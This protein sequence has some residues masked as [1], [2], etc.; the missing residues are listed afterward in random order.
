M[1]IL[2]TL[3]TLIT[4]QLVFGLENQ[5][6]NLFHK[7]YQVESQRFTKN[8]EGIIT[9]LKTGLQW[10]EGPDEKTS[11]EMADAWVSNLS[12]GWRLPTTRE[13]HGIYLKDSKRKGKY[14]DPLCLDEVFERERGYSLW[15]VQRSSNSA[16]IYDF[17]R[18]YAHWTEVMVKG[19]FDRAVAVRQSS[20][21][22]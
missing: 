13:L 8:K 4:S 21:D 5:K 22:K 15:S 9:D 18:G 10:L 20:N 11:W 17:S 12:D 1:R 14:G 19:Y 7:L 3:L 6:Q 16:W 2:V